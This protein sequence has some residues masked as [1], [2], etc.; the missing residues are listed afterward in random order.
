MKCWLSYIF[1]ASLATL[2]LP[3]VTSA[4]EISTRIVGGQESD[5]N[6]FPWA[7]S[8]KDSTTQKHFCGGS[9]IAKQWVLTAAHCLDDLQSVSQITATI[10]E[11]DLDSIPATTA[12]EIEQF[13]IHPDYTSSPPVNDI[14]LLKLASAVA[15][16]SLISPVSLE[17]TTDAVVSQDN[18]TALGWGS[19]VPSDERNDPDFPNI[20]N[21]VEIPL[22]TD[23]M[24]NEAYDDNYTAEMLCAG[25]EDGGKDSCQGDSGGPLVI[26]QDD[27]SW[28][29]IGIV[30]WGSGCAAKGYPGV[31]T[32]LAL[33]E[34]WVNGIL[35]MSQINISD[36]SNSDS[37]SDSNNSGGGGAIGWLTV[38]LFPLL[39][40]RRCYKFL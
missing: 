4:A 6:Q 25:L 15:D 38:L 14:A 36:D 16:P 19:T 18:V 28:Q 11:Y 1:K 31:Y 24:C 20:L 10:G 30:S 23:D 39:F 12:I 40:I 17:D 34:D 29:Q 22:L 35:W 8:L 37:N 13:Y 21:Y 9:L 2:C 26:K 32:R 27:D 5:I 7:V 3:L 33:Y